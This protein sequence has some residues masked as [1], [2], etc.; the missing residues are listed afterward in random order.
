MYGLPQAGRVANDALVKQLAAD[1]HPTGLTSRTIQAQTNSIMFALVV[2]DFGVQYTDKADVAHLIARF[3]LT[4]NTPQIGKAQPIASTSNGIT[5]QA[6]SISPCQATPRSPTPIYPS[7][8]QQTM[9]PAN[10]QS[11]TMVPNNIRSIT[12]PPSPQTPRLS[13][14]YTPFYCRAIDL[15]MPHLAPSP[16]PAE[17]TELT[18]DA[19]TFLL[20][21]CA[22]HPDAVLRYRRSGMILHVDSDASYLSERRPDR[23][24]EDFSFWMT[25]KPLEAICLHNGAIHVER[26]CATLC[27]PPLTANRLFHN[28]Q[29]A[30]GIRTTLAEMGWPATTV[31]VR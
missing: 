4:T 31:M 7:H 14:R 5:S 8:S 28:C 13:R 2:D 20:N 17:A 25:R 12:T 3:R 16:Q 27:L 30:C 24:L 18:M 9:P 15:T 1:D 10:G 23:A 29:V 22:T 19:V 6:L 11:P 21:Y 26:Y